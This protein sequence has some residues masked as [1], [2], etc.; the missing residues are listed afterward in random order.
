MAVAMDGFIGERGAALQGE[1]SGTPI[2]TRA[3]SW[4]EAS[5]KPGEGGRGDGRVNKESE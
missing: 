4:V 1:R 3:S 5:L 2:R